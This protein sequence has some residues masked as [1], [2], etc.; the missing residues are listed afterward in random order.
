M[1]WIS[2]INCQRPPIEMAMT[3]NGSAWCVLTVFEALVAFQGSHG[4]RLAWTLR[5]ERTTRADEPCDR[6]DD[7]PSFW[8]APYG[9]R[10]LGQVRREFE[11]LVAVGDAATKA[12]D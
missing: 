3:D 5:C 9:E 12:I 2:T 6:P 7:S 10:I 11:G 4:A 1:L 8:R